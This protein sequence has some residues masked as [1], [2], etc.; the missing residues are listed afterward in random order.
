MEK[1]SFMKAIGCANDLSISD[2]SSE[3]TSL[4]TPMTDDKNSVVK[5]KTACRAC[6]SNCGVIATVKNGRVIHLE[7]NPDDPMSKGRMCAKGLSGIQALYNPNRNKYPLIRVGERGE[8]KWKRISWDEAID[9]IADKLMAAKEEFGAES[10][11]CSTGGGGNPEFWSISRFCNIFGTP[12][13]FEPGCAQCY[14]PRM[15]AYDMMYGG[16]N[17]SIADSNA[18]EIYYPDDTPMKCLVLWG[19]APSYS[20]PGSGGGAVSDLRAKGV[21]TV[22]ID[23]RMTPDAA[24]ADV[25][26]PI[27][28]GSDVALMLA[29]IKYII[30]HKSYNEEFVMKWT[31]LPYLVNANTNMLWRAVVSSDPDVP[32]TFMVWDNKTGSAQPLEYPWNDELDVALEGEYV[33]DGVTYKTG[34]Q[35]LKERAAEYTLEKAAELCWL[36]VD[37]IEEAIKIFTENT[38]GGLCIGVAT[39][40]S[41]NSVEAAMAAAIIDMM[42]G[43]VEQ[44]GSLLQRFRDSG[45]LNAI[46]YIVPPAPSK[47]PDEQLAKRLG[48]NEHKG[49]HMWL[50]GHAAS[51]LDT[52]ETGEPYPLKV[53]LERSGNKLVN[54]ADST[55]WAEASKKVDFIVHMYMYPTS[56]SAYAD[57][58]LPTEEWLETDMIIE[59]C[60]KLSVR[61][62]VTHIWETIDETVIWAKIVKRCAQLGHEG[63]QKSFDAEYMG[64]DLPYWDSTVE[65]IDMNLDGTGITWEQLKEESPIEY[66]PLDEYRSYY[67][68]KQTNEKTGKPEGFKTPSRKCELYLE[69]MITLARTGMPYSNCELP[70]ASKDY[71]P[72]PYYIEPHESPLEGSELAKRFPLVMTNGRLPL[73]HHSTLR[74]TPWTREMYPA[75]EVWIHPNAAETY[76]IEDND[77]VWVESLRGKVRGIANVTLGINEGSVYME[78]F[79]NPETLNTETHGWKEMNVNVLAKSDAPYN[80]VVGTYTLRGYLVK[81]YKAD[82]PPEGVWIESKDFKPWLPQPTDPTMDITKGE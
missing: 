54:V 17:P 31:N 46:G 67:V 24:K 80:D 45:A 32:D 52:I 4:D 15:L 70:P 3:L 75:P 25:W 69:S 13:W 34:F 26:L 1:N 44:P 35:L 79:W 63:C 68:Y 50:A 16:T 40:Q 66:R 7:S 49:L 12:N 38:P 29:W 6:I 43:N 71:D 72:L 81:V 11:F 65:L 36:Q 21:K 62:A 77:W 51:I 8:N 30:D 33:I 57:M 2:K 20:S 23:P 19:A 64:N 56:F 10:V 73:F 58:L 28:P 78:R 61:Q 37:K 18:H 9:T 48:G 42:M 5:I 53:W 76:G 60:N 82:G 27:R 59:T 47:L 74:N 39:D 55:R 22:V 41:P 14:L